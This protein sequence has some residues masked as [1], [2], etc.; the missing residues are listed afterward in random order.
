MEW[1]VG[2]AFFAAQ[3]CDLQFLRHRSRLFQVGL[4]H[5]PWRVAFKILDLQV[6]R[7]LSQSLTFELWMAFAPRPAQ[8]HVSHVGRPLVQIT[9]CLRGFHAQV[10]SVPGPPCNAV[11]R[12]AFLIDGV[13]YVRRAGGG[14][15]PHKALLCKHIWRGRVLRNRLPERLADQASFAFP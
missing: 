6:F 3:D 11:E 9:E 10:G 13:C 5:C 2:I 4:D 12:S 14:H 8:Q 15:F 7:S 1:V